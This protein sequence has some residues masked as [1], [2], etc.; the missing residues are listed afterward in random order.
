MNKPF[1]IKSVYGK[2]NRKGQITTFILIGLL[3]IALAVGIYLTRDT[4]FRGIVIPKE[5]SVPEQAEGIRQYV[6][7]CFDRVLNDG[8]RLISSQGGYINIPEDPFRVGSSRNFLPFHEDNK[9]AYWFYQADNLVNV[10]QVPTTNLMEQE[11]ASYVEENLFTCLG[12]FVDFES[13]TIIPGAVNAVVNI[14]TYQVLSRIDFPLNVNRNDF[15]FTFDQF[16]SVSDVPLGD[17]YSLAKRVFDEENQQFFFEK[18]TL[19]LM[20][21]Y[22][23]V[24]L[25]GETNDCI[26]PVWVTE[27]VKT[28][29]KR[30]LRDNVP[31]FRVK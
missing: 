1:L 26:A 24:P 7:Q 5:L 14:K 28:D 6:Q 15:E 9:V 16:Y 10:N 18:K 29:L 21:F 12:N 30:I 31:H 19:D 23:E 27:Q 2:M 4:L 17:L 20:S 22:D 8:I 13:F 3:V 25:V 11:L